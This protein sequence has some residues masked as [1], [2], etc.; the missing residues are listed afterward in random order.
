M[1]FSLQYVI[2]VQYVKIC[3]LQYVIA[4]ACN[5]HIAVLLVYSCIGKSLV[6]ICIDKSHKSM[7]FK[8][9]LY[10]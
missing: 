1:L 6:Y 3:S 9:S 10:Q 8:T 7:Y 4:I 2:A 5:T